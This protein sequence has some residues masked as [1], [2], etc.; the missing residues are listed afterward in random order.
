MLEVKTI[1]PENNLDKRFSVLICSLPRRSN[2]LARLLDKL[3]PQY[4]KHSDVEVLVAFD[5]GEDTIGTKR[6]F[7]VNQSKGEYIAFVDDDDLVSDN[8]LDLIIKAIETNPDVVGI[9]LLYYENDFY[10]GKAFH[11][12]KYDYWSHEK[13]PLHPDLLHFH[14]CPNHL[15]PVKREL[16]IQVPFPELNFREDHVYSKNLRHL[17]DTEVYIHEEPHIGHHMRSNI[18]TH[19]GVMRYTC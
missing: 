7:L 1:T 11:T 6:N 9:E 18:K 5:N 14:R 13:D 3:K 12:M 15:N 8:Y 4:E 10:R 19:L 2:L 17:L 16:A